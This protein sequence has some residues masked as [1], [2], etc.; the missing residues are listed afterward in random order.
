MLYKAGGIVKKHGIT[1]RYAKNERQNQ[2]RLAYAIS[3]KIIRKAHHRNKLKRWGRFFLRSCS[4]LENRS[5]DF[6][7][8]ITK[9]LDNYKEFETIMT[10]LVRK[11]K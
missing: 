5:L 3:K 2:L 11:V 6:L 8:I 7:I 1:L 10:D 9:P 4:N